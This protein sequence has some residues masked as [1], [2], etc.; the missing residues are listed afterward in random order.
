[1]TDLFESVNA[2]H[3]KQKRQKL[4][5]TEGDEIWWLNERWILDPILE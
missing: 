1:M 5:Q 2:G 4:S 3:K